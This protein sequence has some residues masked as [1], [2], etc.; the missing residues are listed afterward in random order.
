[1]VDALAARWGF[2]RTTGNTSVWFH[3]TEPARATTCASIR[4]PSQARP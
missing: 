3:L 2:Q 4:S 1:M